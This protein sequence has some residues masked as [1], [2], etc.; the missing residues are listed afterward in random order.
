MFNRPAFLDSVHVGRPAAVAGFS[1]FGVLALS[2]LVFF[3]WGNGRVKRVLF[4][5]LEISGRLVSEERML[6]NHH[7]LEADLRELVD[8]EILGPERHDAA[9]LIPRE[10]TVRSLFVRSRVLYLDLSADFVTAGPDY[11]LRGKEALDAMRRSINFNFPRVREVAVTIDG[12]EP[13]FPE[14]KKIR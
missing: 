1:L 6:A 11:P 2:L 12:Q 14:K 13:R 7:N 10:L 4:F 8:E 5:P 9:L 3:I